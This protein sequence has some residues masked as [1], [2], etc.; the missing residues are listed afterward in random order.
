VGQYYSVRPQPAGLKTI[1]RTLTVRE[2]AV[3]VFES[4]RGTLLEALADPIAV[5]T[6]TVPE[7]AV[8]PHPTTLVMAPNPTP[9]VTIPR[10]PHPTVS[11]MP[12]MGAMVIRPIS[13]TDREIDRLGFRCEQRTRR[14]EHNGQC[15]YDLLFHIHLLVFGRHSRSGRYFF[16]FFV[17]SF[18]AAASRSVFFRREARFLT[19]SLPWLF[20]IRV[21]LPLETTSSK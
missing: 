21:S 4:F 9:A 16:P 15:Y 13:N 17:V 19:L 20:P 1:D 5:L 12:V 3:A 11:F 7:V 8:I 2:S 6:M 14:C 10:D 18:L